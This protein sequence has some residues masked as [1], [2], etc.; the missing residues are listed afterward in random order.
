MVSPA[1]ITKITYLQFYVLI[2]LTTAFVCSVFFNFLLHSTCIH[3]FK[4]QI[5]YSHNFT[6]FSVF[7]GLFYCLLFINGLNS[8][9]LALLKL[10]TVDQKV[11]EDLLFCLIYCHIESITLLVFQSSLRNLLL[12]GPFSARSQ[13]FDCFWSQICWRN[14][15]YFRLRHV[16]GLFLELIQLFIKHFYLQRSQLLQSPLI[17]FF[18]FCVSTPRFFS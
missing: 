16:S 6:Q 7:L 3:S 4:A 13:C 8:Q 10:T 17:D 12:N 9:F 11:V 14:I 2:N 18:V 15:L 1:S 5:R